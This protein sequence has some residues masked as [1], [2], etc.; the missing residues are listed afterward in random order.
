MRPSSAP[1][2]VGS[3][4]IAQGVVLVVGEAQR[5]PLAQ[6]ARESLSILKAIRLEARQDAI[7]RPEDDFVLL[8][9]SPGSDVDA[10]ALPPLA[11]RAGAAVA[12]ASDVAEGRAVVAR[13][14]KRLRAQGAA[15]GPREL[16]LSPGDFGYLGLESDGLRERLQV[17]LQGLANDAERLRLRREGWEDPV[18]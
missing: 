17:L 15:L 13:A 3:V 7:A 12:V 10:I 8:L 9:V 4:P 16:V 14:R 6:L 1:G 2:P 5:E 11:E 18:D